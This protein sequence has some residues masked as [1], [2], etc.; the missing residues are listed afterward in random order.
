MNWLNLRTAH[1]RG[2][3][4]VGSSPMERGVWL[5]VLAYCAEVENGGRIAGAASWKS[6]QWQ[7]ACGVTRN[8]ID[9]T[10][11]LLSW[12]G[13][14][15]IV[16]N[17]PNEKEKEVVF[18]RNVA[19]ENGKKGGRPLKNG[20]VEEPTSETNEKP[21]LVISDNQRPKAGGERKEKEKGMEPPKPPIVSASPMEGFED[22]WSEYPNKVGKG[23]ARDA[24]KKHKCSPL[25][26]EIIGAVGQSKRSLGWLKDS[27]RF[28][29]NPATWLNQSRWEDTPA[30][31]ETPRVEF[32]SP[33]RDQAS[34]VNQR[35]KLVEMFE[36]DAANGVE[37]AEEM[38]ADI[39][40]AEAERSAQ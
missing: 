36:R 30:P 32:I 2:P 7:Q 40:L 21:T 39:R 37:G 24:W 18:K 14:D 27:G 3:E 10:T 38:L 4:F 19:V 5:C 34:I 23:K 22:F 17:Y 16:W 12:N 1:L 29:P 26:P 13:E 28:V 11:R 25:T 33:F 6:R 15:L 35:K 20:S 9:K 8:E 31:A